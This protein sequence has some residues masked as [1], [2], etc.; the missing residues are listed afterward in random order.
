MPILGLFD[1]AARNCG[2]EATTTGHLKYNSTIGGEI[3]TGSSAVL[4]D[5]NWHL[6]MITF[7]GTVCKLYV[8]GQPDGTGT[9]AAWSH[10]VHTI[11]F[12][13]DNDTTGETSLDD[14]KLKLNTESDAD[15]LTAYTTGGR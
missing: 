4:N 14:V 15:A 11:G 8:D 10:V 3:F 5:G 1:E 2:L 6:V 7:N 12:G 9:V 13:Q